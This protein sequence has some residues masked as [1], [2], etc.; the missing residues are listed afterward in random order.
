MVLFENPSCDRWISPILIENQDE[1]VLT[2]YFKL[3]IF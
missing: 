3:I 2:E 1:T